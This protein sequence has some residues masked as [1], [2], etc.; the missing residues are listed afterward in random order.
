VRSIALC[1]QSIDYRLNRARRRSIGMVIDHGGL[2]VRAPSWVSIREIE[3]ALRERAEWVIRTLA[4][5]RGRDKEALPAQWREGAAL[6]YRGR[7]LTL[8]LF[9]ARK[10]TIAA[11]LLHLTVLHPNPGDE[12]EIAAFV[13]RWLKEQALALL[14]PRVL[15]FASQVTRVSPAVKLSSARTQW[16]S[17][18]HKGEIR[19]HWRLVQL[20]PAIA[21]YVIAHEVAHLV[22]L[23]HSPRF[24]ALVES[25]LP[26]HVEARRE[27]D[28]MTPVLG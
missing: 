7:P 14:A 24:W 13:G 9:P 11:D 6:L 1:D 3:L 21:D 18:N 20:P 27:L 10:K 8:A 23:N 5:W 4:E 15:H 12:G 2:S 22:E 17:C 25:L 28:A 16:G 19:L 26:G